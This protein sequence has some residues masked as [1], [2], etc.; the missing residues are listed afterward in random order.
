MGRFLFGQKVGLKSA[1]KQPSIGSPVYLSSYSLI[2]NLKKEKD[3]LEVGSLKFYGL[4][5]DISLKSAGEPRGPMLNYVS[6][7]LGRSSP[8]ERN[9]RDFQSK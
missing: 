1:Q 9:F 8:G 6:S 3:K 5:S 2:S 7:D 4:E